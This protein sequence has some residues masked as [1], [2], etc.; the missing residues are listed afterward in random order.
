MPAEN[1][2]R[3]TEAEAREALWSAIQD[4]GA[5]ARAHAE[6]LDVSP[7]PDPHHYLDSA[8]S[9]LIAA[10]VEQATAEMR[11][12]L[13]AISGSR[14]L[15]VGPTPGPLYDAGLSHGL[16]HAADVADYHLAAALR[17]ERTSTGET[18]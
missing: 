12:G 2:P 13:T 16:A 10:E 14:N 7:W 4:Y 8:L 6:P 1:A 17:G 9:A 3:L 18:P 5:A 15:K 11:M